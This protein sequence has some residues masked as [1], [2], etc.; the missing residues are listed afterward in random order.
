MEKAILY[1]S[2][3]CTACRGCQVACKSW[4]EHE[5]EETTSQGSYENPEELSPETWVKMRFIETER[6]GKFAWLFAR[7]ACMHCT[8]ASCSIVCPTGAILKTDEGFV[9]IDQEWCIGCGN[10]VQACPF[11]VPHK[12]H[13]H[14]GT[15][16]K[17]TGCTSTGLNRQDAGMAPACV[18]TCPTGA[19]KFGNRD[20]L[21]EEANQRVADLKARG[22]SNAN[23]YGKDE[24]GGLHVMY[25]LDDTVE[26]YGLPED[27]QV[28]SS[29]VIPKWLTGV[30]TAGVIAAL[31]LWFVFKRKQE[32]E[33]RTKGG[34]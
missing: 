24:L 17:C 29:T 33:A 21:I 1:D 15:A 14:T 4:N 3:K 5:A 10:C 18:T 20:E 8:D 25:I 19:L 2:S 27:P 28:A 13:H 7:R 34:A 11:D 22:M 16:M 26:A 12:D 6:N 30:A 32:L 31:P 23:L 9:H